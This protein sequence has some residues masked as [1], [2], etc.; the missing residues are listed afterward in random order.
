MHDGRY[1][2][3]R[4]ALVKARDEA[5]LTQAAVARRLGRSQSFVSKYENGERRLD[6]VELVDVCRALRQPA[7]RI[8]GAVEGDEG[9]GLF[10]RWGIDER[11]L[12][13]LVDT[14]G[15]LRGM[16]LGYVAETKFRQ[17]YLDHPDIT[18]LGKDPDQDR[19]RK[20]DRNVRYR[21][22]H[23]RIEVKSLQT[24]SVK[25]LG[26]DR[27]TGKSQ[28]DGSDKRQVR[29]RDGSLLNTTLLLRGEFDILAVNCFAFG[30]KWRF[31]FA[32]NDDLPA[33]TH[34]TYSAEQGNQLIA[35]LVTVTWPPLPP[36]TEDLHKLLRKTARE[37]RPRGGVVETGVAEVVTRVP[38]VA[39]RPKR[40]R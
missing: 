26:K 27:W 32:R 34:R 30:G 33:S 24:A 10:E 5:G 4:D 37:P 20:G 8:L 15:R 7:G 22:R 1:A 21:G 6:V 18:D 12:T 19:K 29:L 16:M 28:V 38:V 31:V 17:M 35:S 36:F 11:V 3:L 13:D 23:M 14:N 2:A 25:D 40:R 39:V 9:E